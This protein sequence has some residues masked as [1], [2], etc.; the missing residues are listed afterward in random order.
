MGQTTIGI[1]YGYGNSV[2]LPSYYGVCTLSIEG[3]YRTHLSTQYFESTKA[4]DG[5]YPP[6][7]SPIIEKWVEFESMD[8]SEINKYT[9]TN[10]H[11]SAN[12]RLYS[13]NTY[14]NYSYY[15]LREHTLF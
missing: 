8:D 11:F 6:L 15:H 14:D 7:S 13:I 9:R 5:H 4:E 12:S 3:P 1:S 10:S 2:S